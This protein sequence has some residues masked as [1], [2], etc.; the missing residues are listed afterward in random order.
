[1]DIS[2]PALDSINTGVS[3]AFNE[4]L[5][6]APGIYKKFSYDASSTGSEEIYPRLDMIPG[7]REWI[8]ERVVNWLTQ[9]T[10]AIKNKTFESTIGVKR[11]DIEDDKYGMLSPVAAQMGQNAGHL[12]DLLVAGLMKNGHTTLGIDGQNFFDTAH[13][14]FDASGTAT[15]IANYQAGSGNPSWYLI[16]TS[17]MLKPFIYQTRRPF[18]LVPKFSLEAEN[19]FWQDEFIWGVDGRANAGYGLW[20]LAYRS[21]AALTVANLETAR[22]TMAS[23]RRPDGA[24]MGITGNMLIVPTTLY[25]QARAYCENEFLPAGDPAIGSAGTASNTFRGLATALENVWLN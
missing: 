13:A 9:S 2:F 11:E 20:Q 5:W 22:T 24:P 19:V 3:T 18:K 21:D 14:N 15:T 23:W 1:M 10:F 6:A 12:A 17:K 16:D 4:Q 25:P 7:L 8:G